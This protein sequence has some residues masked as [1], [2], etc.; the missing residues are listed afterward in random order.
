MLETLDATTRCCGCEKKESVGNWRS[1]CHGPWYKCEKHCRAGEVIR[2]IKA[3]R[4]KAKKEAKEEGRDPKLIQKKLKR[5]L[6]ALEKGEGKPA[7]QNAEHL[8]LRPK[9]N[10]EMRKI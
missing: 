8:H 10:D 7:K 2:R 3:N 5:E 1:K 4:T 9:Y 6:N